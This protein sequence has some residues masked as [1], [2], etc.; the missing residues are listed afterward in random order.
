MPGS[1]MP[2]IFRLGTHQLRNRFLG[3]VTFDY[4]AVDDRMWH[5]ASSIGTRRRRLTAAMSDSC[6]TVTR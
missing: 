2:R 4:I 1:A 6:R 5:D 3:D